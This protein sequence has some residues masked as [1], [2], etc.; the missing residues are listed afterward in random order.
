MII[1]RECDEPMAR[2]K[3][4]L[5]CDH[6]CKGCVACICTDEYGHRFHTPIDHQG[7]GDPKLAIRNWRIKSYYGGW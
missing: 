6:R 2:S 3:R 7:R 1:K 5:P 4:L